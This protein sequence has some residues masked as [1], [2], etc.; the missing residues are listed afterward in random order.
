M[1][2]RI[3][4]NFELV[5]N[6]D[7]SLVDGIDEQKQRLFIFLKTL[8]GSLSYA[9]NWGLDY[10]LLLKFLKINNLQAVKN[11]F[12]EISK[13]L[14]LDLSNISTTIKDRKVHISF[15]FSGDVL[16]MEFDL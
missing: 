11:Y 12:H 8:K 5:F 9:P 6:N 10:F 3:G 7:V 13:E 1:D 2:L 16:N 14:N 15:F 4:N